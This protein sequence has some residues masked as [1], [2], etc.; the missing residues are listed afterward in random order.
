MCKTN[1]KDVLEINPE[2]IKGVKFHYVST[3][4]EVIEIALEKAAKGKNKG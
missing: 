2:Y 3:M 1:K 4:M